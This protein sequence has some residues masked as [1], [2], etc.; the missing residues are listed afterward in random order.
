MRQLLFCFVVAIYVSECMIWP[1]FTDYSILKS[2]LKFELDA[3][4]AVKEGK[5]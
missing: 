1:M 4:F 3:L 2:F 5:I